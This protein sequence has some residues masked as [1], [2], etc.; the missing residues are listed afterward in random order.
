M[1]KW[2]AAFFST[3]F[4]ASRLSKDPS[5]KV[6]ATIVSDGKV[7]SWGF[8]GLPRGHPDTDEYLLN[9]DLKLRL[10][11]HAERNAISQ[12]LNNSGSIRGGSI[13]ITHCP[14]TDCAKGIIQAGIKEVNFPYYPEFEK[15]WDFEF[16]AELLKRCGV[17]IRKFDPLMIKNQIRD[18]FQIGMNFIS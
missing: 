15:R 12:A 3:A 5:T 16:T 11:E 2:D 18:Q 17:T 10:V 7:I 8:N 14:C 1:N 6:G 9:R 13:Y 4:V